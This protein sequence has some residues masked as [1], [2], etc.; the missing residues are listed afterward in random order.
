MLG[1]VPEP[2]VGWPEIGDRHADLVRRSLACTA[3]ARRPGPAPN[4]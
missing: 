1:R 4:A 2:S 3:E